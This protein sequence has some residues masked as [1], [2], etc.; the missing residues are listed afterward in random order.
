MESLKVYLS[1]GIKYAAVALILSA[2]VCVVLKILISEKRSVSKQSW[3]MCFVVLWYFIT[4]ELVVFWNRSNDWRMPMSFCNLHLFENLRDAVRSASWEIMIQVSLNV[5]MFVPG[6]IL[7]SRL[8]RQRRKLCVPLIL[9]AIILF[10][11]TVQFFSGLGAADVDD[12]AANLLGGFWGMALYNLYIRRRRS[13]AQRRIAAVA[14]ALPVFAV[15]VLSCAYLLKPWGYLPQDVINPQ[16]LKAEE[17]DV[18]A[19][20]EALPETLTVYKQ[21]HR[22]KSQAAES[23]E[24]IFS[25]VGERVDY[26]SEDAY[27]NLVVYRGALN[28]SNYIWYWYKGDFDLAL[29]NTPVAIPHS[30]LPLQERLLAVLRDMGYSLPTPS[31]FDSDQGILTYEFV[32]EG[33]KMYRGTVDFG[34]IQEEEPAL[35]GLIYKVKELTEYRQTKALNAAGIAEKLQRG[36]FTYRNIEEPFT[37]EKIV[38]SDCY[39]D[40]ALD[41]KGYY[42]PIYVISCTIDGKTA[43]IRVAA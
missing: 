36:L 33:N 4:M 29:P 40:Y 24:K 2:V 34:F 38:C 8:F 28:M 21:V 42:R 13:G 5:L 16:Y 15:I 17:V 7:L 27:D 31:G 3:V 11:E 6:G 37:V 41:T 32:P 9:L 1:I 12:L 43:E 25:A 20:E 39:I 23:V 35:Y 30:D 22:E 26:N 19:L 14:A 10:N 18:S